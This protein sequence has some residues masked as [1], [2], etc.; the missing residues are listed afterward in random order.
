MPAIVPSERE[1]GDVADMQK[2]LLIKARVWSYEKEWRV[3]SELSNT[4]MAYAPDALKRVI[5]GA[6]ATTRTVN[7]LK[8][9]VETERIEIVRLK[10]ANDRFRLEELP[11]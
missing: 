11:P 6:N 1:S 8:R 5:V 2:F 3:V 7:A 4:T 9:A 10:L